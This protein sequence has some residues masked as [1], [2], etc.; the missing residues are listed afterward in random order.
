VLDIGLAKTY[1][2]KT[3]KDGKMSKAEREF[4]RL[5]KV[6][7]ANRKREEAKKNPQN[8]TSKLIDSV[9]AHETGHD[10]AD[11]YDSEQANRKKRYLRYFKK[12]GE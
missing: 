9:A 10:T 6:E 2:L 8:S 4:E 5:R 12:D 7:E 3:R 11:R 1:G